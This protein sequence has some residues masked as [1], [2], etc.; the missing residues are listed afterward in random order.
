MLEET[1]PGKNAQEYQANDGKPR[2]ESQVLS[3]AD[4]FTFQK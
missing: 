3:T 2:A 1:G 4:T